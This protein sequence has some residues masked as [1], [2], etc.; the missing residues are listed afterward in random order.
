MSWA[1]ITEGLR[2]LF[3]RKEIDDELDDEVAQFLEASAREHMARGLSRADAERA[4]RIEFGGVE[5]AKEN[6]RAA[7]WDGALDSFTRDVSGGVRALRRNPTFAAVTCLTLA[8]GIGVNTAMFTVVNAVLLR[9]LPY[10]RPA[11]LALIW[12]DDTRRGLHEERT[13]YRTILDWRADNHTMQGIGFYSAGRAQ[14]GNDDVRE[15]TRAAYVS[16]NL[17]ALLGTRPA[18]GRPISID[19]EERAEPV[20]VI[21]HSLWQRRFAGDSN[22]VGK[23]LDAGDLTKD[24][25]A[26]ERIVGVMP[27]DFYFPDKLTEVW[28]PATVYWRFRRESAERFPDWARRWIA[29]AR[30]RPGA[31]VADAR[32]DLARIGARLSSTYRTDFPDFPGFATNVV[33]ILDHVTGRNVQRALWLLFGA[34]GLVLL[35]ACANV[36]NLLLARSSARQQELAVRRALGASRGRLARQLLAESMVLS[37]V[38]GALGLFVGIGLTRLVVVAGTSRI[39]RMDE[40]TFDGRV[41]VFTLALSLVAGLVFGILPAIRA[42]KVD[43]GATLKASRASA[44]VGARRTR[45]LLVVAECALA[46]VLLVGAG[47]LVRS[48]ARVRAVDPGFDASHVLSARLILPAEP[49]PSAEER[50]QASQIDPARARARERM[51]RDLAMRI[52]AVPGVEHVGFIDDM[53]IT[54]S[55]NKSI[56][57]PGRQADSI[58]AGELNEGSVTPEFFVALRVPLRAGRMPTLDD[59]DTKIRALWSPVITDQALEEKERRAIPEPVVVNEAFVRR[60][61]NGEDPIGKRFCIDPT[62]KTYWYEIVGVVGDMHRQG[63]EHATV[64]EYFGP[65]VPSANGRVDLLIRVRRDPTAYASTIRQIVRSAIPGVMIPSVSTAERQLGEFS[66]ERSFQTWLLAAFAALALVLAMIGVYGVLHYAVAERTNE[67]GIRMALGA[68]PADVMA[69]ALRQGMRFPLIGLGLGVAGSFAVTRAMEH[70]LFETRAADATTYASVVALLA[71]SALIA[72][73]VP[74]RRAAAIDPI[75]ALRQ[76]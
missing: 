65:Y 8:L 70:L 75:S 39:P 22:V 76:E 26:K 23:L 2:R 58:G 10:A 17:F 45:D 27:Q 71:A 44:N 34:V 31:G 18:L 24:P 46:I 5:S 61:F 66:A 63:L 47:L 16:G 49:P 6:I 12:T 74:A 72:C 4:A 67:I 51:L 57:I 28:T 15:M 35:V 13:A 60:F 43:P 68:S 69:M 30:L 1:S 73:Y 52:A 14:L 11:S 59:A 38:G 62:N 41:F 50:R 48:L 32:T 64:A 21:S 9:P 36:A 55:A 56:T 7:G 33:P 3:R 37:S 53:F 25:G 19:D 20:A 40:T 29:V 54:S 42:S